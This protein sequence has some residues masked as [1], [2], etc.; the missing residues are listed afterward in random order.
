MRAGRYSIQHFALP[1]SMTR[2]RRGSIWTW[3]AHL[4]PHTGQRSASLLYGLA[5]TTMP[6]PPM[7]APVTTIFTSVPSVESA[8]CAVL[9]AVRDTFGEVESRS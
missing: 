9:S 3:Q 1:R 6:H 8:P 2:Q 7:R 5:K 4:L